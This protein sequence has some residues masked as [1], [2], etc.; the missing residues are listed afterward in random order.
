MRKWVVMICLVAVTGCASR[1]QEYA[2]PNEDREELAATIARQGQEPAHDAPPPRREDTFLEKA[3]GYTLFTVAGA[4]VC[5][6]AAPAVLGLIVLKGMANA[7][8]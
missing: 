6:L 3:A 7:R 8:Q 5:V 4:G 1:Q 2:A